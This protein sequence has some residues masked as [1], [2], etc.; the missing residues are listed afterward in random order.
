MPLLA[1]VYEKEIVR[2]YVHDAEKIDW[3][4]QYLEE[5]Q[6]P[7]KEFQFSGIAGDRGYKCSFIISTNNLYNWDKI[8]EVLQEKFRDGIYINE[9]LGT[10]SI[11]GEGFSRNNDALIKTLKLLSINSINYYGV[12]TTSFRISI[13][14]EKYL[15]EEAVKI[16]HK[17][18]L[19]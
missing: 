1:V 2:I 17:F 14:V 9:S 4:L 13:L 10:L 19:E 18:W 8:K 12:N 6:I 5:N 15:L 7:I 16:C 3:V 11:I